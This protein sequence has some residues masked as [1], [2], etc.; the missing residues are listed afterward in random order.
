MHPSP[1]LAGKVERADVAVNAFLQARSR[2]E[3]I[4][5]VDRAVRRYPGLDPEGRTRQGRVRRDYAAVLLTD[6]LTDLALW[7]DVH[8]RGGQ[9]MLR[10]LRARWNRHPFGKLDGPARHMASEL[11]FFATEYSVFMRGAVERALATYT[12]EW[13]DAESHWKERSSQGTAPGTTALHYTLHGDAEGAAERE[14]L[15]LPTAVAA[16]GAFLARDRP[17]YPVTITRLQT[18]GG[19]TAID[20]AELWADV[21][22][23]SGPAGEWDYVRA[24]LVRPGTYDVEGGRA[25]G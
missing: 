10:E 23:E 6:L 25:P 17:E 5:A 11:A 2:M 24:A 15:F 4:E 1:D 3:D 7:E 19:Q 21:L 9:E 16:L 22:E 13:R 14:E 18:G 12:E 20:H 8:G